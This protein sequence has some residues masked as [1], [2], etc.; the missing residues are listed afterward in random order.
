[1]KRLS[2]VLFLILSAS[3]S[4]LSQLPANL[5]KQL[6]QIRLLESDQRDLKRILVGYDATDPLDHYQRFVNEALAVEVNYSSGKCGEDADEES[7]SDVWNVP[8]WKVTRIEISFEDA[9]QTRDIGFDLSR[10][11]K[12]FRFPD[13][14]DSLVYHDKF[15]GL[16]FKTSEDGIEEIIIFP[17]KNKVTNLCKGMTLAEGFYKRKGWFSSSRPY[18]YGCVLVNQFANVEGLDLDATELE[19]T[20]I[21]TV[22]VVTTAR[23]PEGDV[24]TYNYQVSGGCVSGTGARVVWDL[25]GV[26]PGTYTITAGVDDGAG[27]VGRTVTRTVRVK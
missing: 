18:D 20:A 27:I 17:S 25:A 24:L 1:M 8:E 11:K 16:A 14:R 4:V 7:A 6:S 12:D 2:I 13:D 23:D 15:H 21:N 3:S 10:F 5:L 9:V 19:A 26:A 22:S